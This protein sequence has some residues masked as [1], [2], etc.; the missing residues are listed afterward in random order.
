MQVRDF[1]FFFHSIF[2]TFWTDAVTELV[3]FPFVVLRN[4][5]QPILP[6]KLLQ[7]PPARK[8]IHKCASQIAIIFLAF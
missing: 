2:L 5:L 6:K 4:V 8:I 1:S 3:T 7:T